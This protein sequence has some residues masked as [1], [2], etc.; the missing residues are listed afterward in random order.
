MAKTKKILETIGYNGPIVCV[1]RLG[2]I[3][4]SSNGELKIKKV[5]PLK[6]E[7]SSMADCQYI[8]SQAKWLKKNQATTKLYISPILL[9]SELE[10]VKTLRR[11]CDALNKMA[12]PNKAGQN[13]Y[14]VLSGRLFYCAENGKLELYH[15]DASNLVTTKNGPIDKVAHINSNLKISKN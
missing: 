7:L 10:K 4:N 1:Q 9:S 5:W 15:D 14:T 8:L 13:R 6:V 3:N 12:L 2:H 11:R